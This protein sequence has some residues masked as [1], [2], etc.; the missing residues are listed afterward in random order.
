MKNVKLLLIIW[1]SLFSQTLFCQIEL[2]DLVYADG[3]FFYQNKIYTKKNVKEVLITNEKSFKVYE[4]SWTLKALGHGAVVGTA[5]VGGYAFFISETITGVEQHQQIF[6]VGAAIILPVVLTMTLYSS[7][8]KK[9]MKSVEVFN[10]ENRKPD[11]GILPS[12][13]KIGNTQNGVGL[14]LSF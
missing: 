8:N 3:K 9:L 4:Q 2:D 7:S 6:F 14:V 13:L 1:T 10:V 5:L 11:L 12:E